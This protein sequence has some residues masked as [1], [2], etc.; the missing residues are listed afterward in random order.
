MNQPKTHAA[1]PLSST[2]PEEFDSNSTL[3]P[4][5]LHPNVNFY[6]FETEE[7]TRDQSQSRVVFCTSYRNKFDSTPSNERKNLE[8]TVVEFK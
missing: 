7:F 3:I 4:I 6:R 2:V 1:F 5:S 8:T